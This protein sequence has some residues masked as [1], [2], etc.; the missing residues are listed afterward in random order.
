MKKSKT[1]AERDILAKNHKRLN[2]AIDELLNENRDLRKRLATAF[3]KLDEHQDANAAKQSE[4]FQR[5][6]NTCV[7]A[8][9]KEHHL[10]SDKIAERAIAIAHATMTRLYGKDDYQLEI[11]RLRNALQMAV[12][13]HGTGKAPGAAGA[14]S[15]FDH[16]KQVLEGK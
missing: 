10:S 9:A 6:I 12:D 11:E 7:L 13:A 4:Q 8:L 2:K 15:W 5:L 14:G 3:A 16:A 1:E